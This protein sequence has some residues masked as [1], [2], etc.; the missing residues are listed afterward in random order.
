MSGIWL[1][2][3]RRRWYENGVPQARMDAVMGRDHKN[4]FQERESVTSSRSQWSA[5]DKT[6]DHVEV[7]E[8]IRQEF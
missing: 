4:G 7:D 6:I 1:E 5:S 3:K 2:A 8:P